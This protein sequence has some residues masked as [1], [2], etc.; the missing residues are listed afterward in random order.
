MLATLTTMGWHAATGA[1]CHPPVTNKYA[2]SLLRRAKARG[3]LPG[4]G[5][6]LLRICSEAEH[7]D[8]KG[9]TWFGLPLTTIVR[10]S[11]CRYR[12]LV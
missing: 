6:Q 2:V 10:C 1:V 5:E 12:D 11:R 8:Q 9:E 3:A 7:S 4:I